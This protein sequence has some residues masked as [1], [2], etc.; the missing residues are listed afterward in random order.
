M[1]KKLIKQIRNEWTSNIWLFVEL[2]LV[3]VVMWFIVDFVYVQT[4][5][6]MQPRGFDTSNCYKIEMGELTEVSPHY[7][8]DRTKEETEEDIRQLAERLRLRP[9]IK[10]I[11]FGQSSHPYNGSNGSMTIQ[12]D[13]LNPRGHTYRR[14]VS[15]G[16]IE[17]FRYEGANGETPE[18]LAQLLTERSLMASEDLFKYSY[19]KDLTPLIGREAIL[20]GD[21]TLNFRLVAS[22]K[23][24]RY[25]DYTESAYSKTGLLPLNWYD[26]HLE[27]C[28]RVYP[29]QDIDFIEKIRKDSESQ[30]RIGNIYI[31]NVKSFND[32]R[33]N[34]LQLMTNK[35]RNYSFGIAFLLLNIFIGLL[36]TFWFRTQHR[37]SE[38]ALM[39][40]LGATKRDIFIRQIT[41]GFIILC[42]ATIPAIIIDFN[43]AK[44]ELVES[45]NQTTLEPGRF[46]I[47]V[48]ISFALIALMMFIG[49]LIPARR[50]MKIQPAE[51][52]HNE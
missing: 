33:R 4:A 32:I 11:G 42:A 15:P 30:Y 34:Y 39:K 37:R 51:A 28:V 29:D 13:T 9:E 19:E 25:D 47:T 24:I 43:I 44:A 45:Y 20:F 21:S 35:F 14:I 26:T 40:S 48:F 12:I 22:L 50:A 6:Y 36:G 7:I 5:I 1:N 52:L 41:E 23:P 18:Q 27:L 31:A 3:S 2:L 8:P 46:I 38:I 16:F 49:I 10:A 17:V